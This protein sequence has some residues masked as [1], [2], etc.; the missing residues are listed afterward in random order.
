MLGRDRILGGDIRNNKHFLDL[1]DGRGSVD[2]CCRHGDLAVGAY[3]TYVQPL[4]GWK[5]LGS[6]GTTSE[7]TYSL[8]TLGNS[9]VT[10]NDIPT[11]P[12]YA[13]YRYFHSFDA[14]IAS[15][16]GCV[17]WFN[18]CS[19]LTATS[20]S[21]EGCISCF[22]CPVCVEFVTGTFSFMILELVWL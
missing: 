12:L 9:F 4:P 19:N 16:M 10:T 22:V 14:R 17:D 5:L 13:S 1:G 15:K 7:I 18:P 11:R 21:L 20:R 6:D 8:L 3:R 2:D